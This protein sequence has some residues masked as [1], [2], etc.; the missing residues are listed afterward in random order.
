M[1]LVVLEERKI[2][3]LSDKEMI[4]GNQSFSGDILHRANVRI[5]HV[6]F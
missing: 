2:K 5:S 6:D 4:V 3:D 1:L